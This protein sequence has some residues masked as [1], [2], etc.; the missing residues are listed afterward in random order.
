MK[1]LSA[2]AW[3][4][5]LLLLAF[6]TVGMFTL[7]NTHSTGKSMAVEADKAVY[8]ET[9]A[10]SVTVKAVYANIGG[11]HT[12][13]GEDVTVSI[14]TT[15]SSTSATTASWST[16]TTTTLGN[17]TANE[18][19]EGTAYNW[20]A[21]ASD[22]SKGSVQKIQVLSSADLELNEI[23]VVDNMNHIVP[24]LPYVAGTSYA[25]E[26]VAKA[27]DAQEDFE[28]FFNEDGAVVLENNAYDNFTQEEGYYMSSV[29]N[30]MR[31]TELFGEGKHLLD[32]NFNYL[33]SVLFVP[34]VALFGVSVFALR[35]PAFLATCL[36]LVFAFLLMKELTK[37][38]SC[39]FWFAA[40][41]AVGGMMTTV[42]RLG[43]PYALIA[44]ALTGSAYFMYRFF[45]HGIGRD[46]LKGGMNILVSGVFGAFAMAMD[47][48]AVIPV[49]G[50][51]VLFAFG[52]RRQ[53]LARKVAME[54]AESE[55]EKSRV[56]F[57]YGMKDR[58]AYGFASL[59]FVMA[60]FILILIA[61]S[62]CYSAYIRANGEVNFLKMLWKGIANSAK[63]NGVT[64]WTAEN[65]SVLSWFIPFKSTIL[66][67]GVA[68]VAEDNYLVWSAFPN[69]A[70]QLAS[71]VAF[72][73][74]TV[75]F[76]LD[77]AKKR[78]DKYTLRFRRGYILLTGGM[79]AT[80]VA[81]LLRGNVSA[82]TGM[83]FH[84]CYLGFLPLVATLIPE[85]KTATDKTLVTVAFTVVFAVF[86]VVFA[87]GL[88]A[89]YGYAVTASRANWFAWLTFAGKGG[90]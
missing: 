88:P 69:A 4:F 29:R 44:S 67:K 31:G 15:T 61:S 40:A 18:G 82:L 79:L 66:Y 43:A 50:V 49:A 90:F 77:F 55:E 48:T 81:A 33:A 58:V 14:K 46:F 51:L 8:F 5:C 11:I 21:L 41:L 86:A 75:K 47:I 71:A 57:A 74:A 73:G 20:I 63:D 83:L 84:V 68:S 13:L 30:I 28:R 52:L 53:S 45:A 12:S 25:E 22:K 38:E 70:V 9:E 80:L 60:F 65:V 37:K 42:G 24:L 1:K 16:L 85:G 23:V 78:N 7:G 89:F 54:K 39:A 62:L 87:L 6:F 64:A 34:S 32:G 10:G 76:I 3:A 59:G 17:I 72:L 35:L 26:D 27:L 19:L 56:E 36:L 2:Y